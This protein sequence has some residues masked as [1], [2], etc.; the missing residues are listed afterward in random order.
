MRTACGA[1]A[2]FA[3]LL[4]LGCTKRESEP[5]AAKASASVVR[6]GF[7]KSGA[8]ALLRWKKTLEPALEEQHLSVE[9]AEFASGPAL[10]EALNAEQ[11]DLGFVGEAP[12]IFAQAASKDL[13]YV[14]YE[15]P[16]PEGEA[17]LV[18]RD[19]KL[20]SV[21]QLEGHSVALNKGS[22]VHYFLVRALEAAAVPYADVKVVFLPPADARAA[23]ENGTVDAWAIWD[24]YLAA[25]EIA[26]DARRLT[27]AT[28]LAPNHQFYVSRRGFAEQRPAQLK[29]LLEQVAATDAWAL[30][31]RAEAAKFLA[32]QLAIDERAM[33]KSVERASFGVR[34]IDDAVLRSQQ[35]VADAFLALGLL[36]AR[37]SVKDALPARGVR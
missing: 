7:Q 27:D 18:R 23:F 22:N 30:E 29:L 8:L 25:A 26:T 24:P 9:W 15:P 3:L 35:Q 17:I 4:L 12:P 19:S 14:G 21:A 2:L 34:P 6:I 28:G 10:L 11:L 32:E 33:L 37:L 13:V 16:A 31:H 1:F 5:G 36:P 20:T